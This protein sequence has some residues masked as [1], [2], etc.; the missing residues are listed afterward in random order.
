M[1]WKI[2]VVASVCAFAAFTLISLGHLENQILHLASLQYLET[3][4]EPGLEDENIHKGIVK[5]AGQTYC[6]TGNEQ[7]G[8]LTHFDQ[9][10]P[11]AFLQDGWII[12]NGSDEIV[13][14]IEG[15]LFYDAKVWQETIRYHCGGLKI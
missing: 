13:G 7:H 3:M 2:V 14:D 11:Y 5:Y 10:V 8:S 12:K 9:Q 4:N 15:L 6:Y 1:F